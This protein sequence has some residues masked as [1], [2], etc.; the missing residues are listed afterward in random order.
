MASD[1]PESQAAPT[2][3]TPLPDTV[4]APPLSE[5]SQRTAREAAGLTP[6]D[7]SV[8]F[9]QRPTVPEVATAP[10]DDTYQAGR[11][12]GP[13]QLLGE[14]ARGGMGIVHRA[15]DP[16]L[17]R[18]VALKMLRAGAFADGE[19]LQRFYTEARAA[20]KLNHSHIVSIYEV[21]QHEGR[22]FF[23]MAYVPGGS[24]AQHLKRFAAD[25]RAAVVLME[26]VTRAVHHAH[27]KGILHRDLK[28]ANVLL[29]EQGEPLVS[30]FGLAKLTDSGV[31]L[32][33]PGAQLGT[34]AYMAPEQAAGDND[35]ISARSDVWSLGVLLYE[36]LTGRRPFN[37]KK[38]DELTNEIRTSD[39][40]SPRSLSRRLDRNLET[41]VLKCLEKE[42][43]NRYESAEALADDLARWLRH[44]PIQARPAGRLTQCWRWMRRHPWRSVAIVFLTLTAI[45]LPLLTYYLNPKRPLEAIYK[46]LRNNE[47]VT[48]IDATGPPAW[49]K[50]IAGQPGP[51]F[52]EAPDQPFTIQTWGL[53][54]IELVPD[55]QMERYRLE[56]EVQNTDSNNGL[57]GVY[58][59]HRKQVNEHGEQHCFVTLT[60]ADHGVFANQIPD[61]DN[62]ENPLKFGS[63]VFC[64]LRHFMFRAQSPGPEHTVSVGIQQHNPPVRLGG[65]PAPWHKIALEVTPETIRAFWEGQQL[66][67]DLPRRKLINQAKVG[68]EKQ[69]ELAGVELAFPPRTGLGLYLME[70][71]ASFRNVRLIPLPPAQ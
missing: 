2:R 12:F 24:L 21:G 35:R 37:R 5:D 38:P 61:P 30:D 53:C 22:H 71:S 3:A 16:K 49:R 28:P 58:V 8:S 43:A 23:T 65:N 15:R 32:T 41:I 34:P 62:P 54:L 25:P 50:V 19:E 70:S 10:A 31:D 36:L 63:L 47:A 13:Y 57:V 14:I 44:E 33:R 46:K 48:L 42:P 29:D 51:N 66:G 20:A 40:P 9:D 26:K 11:P 18:I 56:L 59:L 39:P 7:R 27:Q 67:G 45:A 69:P 60:F 1:A 55:P 6:V 68:W 17:D 4:S 64:L 52:L